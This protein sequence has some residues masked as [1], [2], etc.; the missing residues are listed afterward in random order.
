VLLID[1]CRNS[2]AFGNTFT[3]LAVRFRPLSFLLAL[4]WYAL[5]PM[6]IIVRLVDEQIDALNRFRF[7]WILGSA[8][9]VLY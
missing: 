2:I 8:Y 5:G 6:M 3:V 1:K 7:G 4:V 9:A